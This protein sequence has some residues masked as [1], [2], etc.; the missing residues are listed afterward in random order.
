MR[1]PALLLPILLTLLSLPLLAQ[2]DTI[3][4]NPDCVQ[5][6]R[7]WKI[8][9]AARDANVGAC[10]G[11]IGDINGDS[12]ADFAVLSGIPWQW[13][14]FY[15]DTGTISTTPVWSFDSATSEPGYP[16][17]GD[18]YGTG[19]NV[20]GFLVL[21]LVGP[22]LAAQRWLHLYRSDSNHL[23]AE[24]SVVWHMASWKDTAMRAVPDDFLAAD[25]DGDGDDELILATRYVDGEGRYGQLWI[26]EGGPG[27]Q[28][29][30]PSV[31][32]KD[33]ELNDDYFRVHAGDIDGDHRI[34]LMTVK[35]AA[36]NVTKAVFY[37]GS[38]GWPSIGRQPDLSVVTG[39]TQSFDATEFAT[40][41]DCDGD[42][43]MD[44]ITE[45]AH[46]WRSGSGKDPHTR[47]WSFPDADIYLKS[48]GGPF[49]PGGRPGYLNSKRYEMVA[50]G[51]SPGTIL[52]SGGPEGP[53]LA[54]DATYYP[55]LDTLQG[56]VPITSPVGD[57]NGDGWDDAI[58]GTEY[59][60]SE[61]DMRGIA[62]I[63]AGGPYIPNDDPALGVHEVALERK[64]NALS[65]WPNPVRDEL[66]IAW[67][68]DLARMPRR[69]EIHDMLGRLVA[70]GSVPDGDGAARWRCSEEPTG[71]YLLSIFD[72]DGIPLASVHFLK[73]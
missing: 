16:I 27:F 56:R 66:N 52:F 40:L 18:F 57:V 3:T 62:V 15:G 64:P 59:Y 25:L 42:H 1:A 65:L 63:V 53:D 41:I 22:T 34:D 37:W 21:K 69:F 60:P 14:V 13:R 39:H 35:R 28:V 48:A 7:I 68:G 61:F 20:V 32:I 10:V 11:G 6:K 58:G 38:N 4:R 43:I 73:R 5:L 71:D 8:E 45:G 24:P 44:V 50:T 47:A 9:G 23:H 49:G 54:Y 51:W 29:D 72:V 55:G 12:L 33:P 30:T 46:I 19:H 17:V 26:Y 70:S 2:G 31:V 36:P 67:R